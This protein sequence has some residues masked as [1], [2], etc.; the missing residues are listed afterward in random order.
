M[1]VT[2]DTCLGPLAVWSTGL[3]TS[4]SPSTRALV[5]WPSIFTD[6][7]IYAGLL[8]RLSSSVP[9]VL[10][11]GPGHGRSPGF[12]TEFSMQD[13][14]RA[15]LKVLDHLSLSKAYIGGT[16]WGGIVGA[17]AAALAP[18]RAHGVVLMNTPLF[19]DQRKPSL[20]SRA[21]SMGARW[22][23][24][25]GVFRNGVAKNFFSP[26]TL[27]ARG[28]YL[29][30]FHQMLR[31]A[32]PI[33]LAAAVRS[34]LLRSTPLAD[35]L[36]QLAVPSLFIAGRDDVMYPVVDLERVAGSMKKAKVAVVPG[37][38][39][40]SVDAPDEVAKELRAWLAV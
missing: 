3:D 40:S 26:A 29:V 7:H 24:S 35:L 25:S 36:P 38:H 31:D 16:S 28:D 5:L 39:I 30:R 21:I 11:D 23:L 12:Q 33:T 34:V 27:K 22:M 32:E 18:K 6:H 4:T 37:K 19:L 1:E 14:A 15:M 13:C 17:H 20:G 10:I 9:I 8:D 2:I